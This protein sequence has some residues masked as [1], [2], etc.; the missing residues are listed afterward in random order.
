MSSMNGDG[1][2]GGMMDGEKVAEVVSRPACPVSERQ[3]REMGDESARKANDEK[4]GLCHL[5]CATGRNE[6]CSETPR[7]AELKTLN[8]RESW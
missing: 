6:M 2:I 8:T 5:P 1:S 3:R 4:L 7:G